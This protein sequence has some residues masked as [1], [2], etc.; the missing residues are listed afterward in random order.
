MAGVGVA[1]VVKPPLW[2]PGLLDG[3]VEDLADRMRM[4]WGT[5]DD[6]EHEAER[7]APAGS[8]GEPLR[9][10]RGPPRAQYGDRL[11]VE[12]ESATTARRLRFADYEFVAACRD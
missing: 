12:V 1:Q 4:Q 6:R 9:G 5:V 3:G 2:K 11:D 8:D 7:V 10:L